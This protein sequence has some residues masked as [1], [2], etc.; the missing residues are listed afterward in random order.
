VAGFR[1]DLRKE[2]IENGYSLYRVAWTIAG[3]QQTKA[4]DCRKDAKR[5]ADAFGEGS[6][7]DRKRPP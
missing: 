6:G 4:F 5:H 2:Q 1:K 7:K 3:K